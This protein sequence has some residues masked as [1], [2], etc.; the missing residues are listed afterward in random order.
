MKEREAI[1]RV[2]LRDVERVEVVPEIRMDSDAVLRF[3]RRR[4]FIL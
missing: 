4:N 3:P 1:H 2:G